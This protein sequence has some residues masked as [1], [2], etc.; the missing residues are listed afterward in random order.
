M[1]KA[2]PSVFYGNTVAKAVQKIPS[3]LL[4]EWVI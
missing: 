4:L 1:Q 3:T 2:T